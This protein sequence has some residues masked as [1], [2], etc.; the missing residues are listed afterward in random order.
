M[1]VSQSREQRSIRRMI[2]LREEGKKYIHEQQ[3]FRDVDNSS[4]HKLINIYRMTSLCLYE[5]EV[6]IK[7]SIQR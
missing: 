2:G 6:A 5:R 3:G 1:K 4:K 7:E